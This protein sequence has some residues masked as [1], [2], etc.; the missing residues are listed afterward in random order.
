M[1]A[2]YN[3]A[4]PQSRKHAPMCRLSV[5]LNKIA[6]LRNSRTT[7]VPDVAAFAR[8]VHAAGAHGIT[9]HPR[10]DQRHIR[11]AD[12]AALAAAIAHWRPS[13]E[14]N[15]EGRPDAEFM[16]L[17]DSVRPEQCTLVPDAYDVLTSDEG[18][19]LSPRQVAL[20]RPVVA[21]LKAWGCRAILFLD[22]DAAQVALAPQT[23][24]DGV[25]FYTGGYAAD[26][27]RGTHAVS[28]AAHAKAA[29]A[30]Q[31][32]GLVANAGHDLTTRNIPP[33]LQACPHIAEMSIGHE[34]TADALAIG[35]DAAVKAYLAAMGS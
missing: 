33:Y 15:I 2:R 14:Y 9:I 21:Q 32:L 16:Q 11:H 6:L 18:W 27:R 34:L 26:F 4:T 17:V 13:F 35:F 24:A 30:A 22:P 20:L 1:G 10:P 5:N 7:G 19:K 3:D 31:A 12:V 28:L 23:G 8:H 29:A 25:E